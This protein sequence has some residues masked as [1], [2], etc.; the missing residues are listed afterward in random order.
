MIAA[1]HEYGYGTSRTSGN[2]RYCAAV[3]G[4]VDITRAKSWRFDL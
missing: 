1:V 4:Q 2:V 3:G